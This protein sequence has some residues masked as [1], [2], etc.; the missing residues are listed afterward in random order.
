[1]LRVIEINLS[2]IFMEQD[3]GHKIYTGFL[4]TFSNLPIIFIINIFQKMY[5][6]LYTEVL[7]ILIL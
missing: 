1:M 2:M 7:N 3:L 6:F 5:T 4:F